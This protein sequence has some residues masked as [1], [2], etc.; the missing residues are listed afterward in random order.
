MKKLCICI[1]ALL[2]SFMGTFPDAAMSQSTDTEGFIRESTVIFKGRIE[3]ERASNLKILPASDQTVLV[4]I[5]EVPYAAKTM[6]DLKNEQVTVQLKEP[7]SLKA[8]DRA[9]FFTMGWLYGEN[10]ALREA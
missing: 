2:G 5:E 9:T 7:N 1:A 4:R 10:V 8:G 3:K 6:T